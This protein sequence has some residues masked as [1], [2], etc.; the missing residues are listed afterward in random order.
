MA[1]RGSEV[2]REAG[3]NMR[4]RRHT[5]VLTRA[6]LAIAALALA[7]AGVAAQGYPARPVTLI[8]PYPAGGIA[9]STARTL[10]REL[11]LRLGQPLIIENRVGAGGII[12]MEA[13]ARATPDGH[14]L[15][16]GSQALS[17]SPHLS[18]MRFDP[19]KDIAPVSLVIS[20]S[21]VIVVAAAHPAR[22]LRDLIAMA[23]EKPESLTY[24]TAGV[25]G[26]SHLA[27]E[28]L[29]S[30]TDTRFVMVPFAGGGPALTALLGGHINWMFDVVPTSV[31]HI[32]SGRLRA[33]GYGGAQRNALLPEVPTVAETVPGFNMSGWFGVYAPAGTPPAIVDLL[34]RHVQEILK[35]APIRQGLINSGLEVEG[36]APE[37]FA[38]FIREQ[39]GVYGKLIRDRNI[40]PAN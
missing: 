29:A 40:K 32:R 22:S 6:C 14:T 19:L 20:Y 21:Q 2:G 33:L 28:M 34:G 15:T 8:V 10:G 5:P 25:G 9:D 23:K 35:A 38:A 7:S 18:Q 11:S 26:A 37:A 30:A 12:G 27:S 31:A 39:Y 1:G 16:Y 17:I 36:G 13:G 24:G 3:L 4:H